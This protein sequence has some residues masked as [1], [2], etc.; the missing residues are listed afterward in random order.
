MPVESGNSAA[1]RQVKQKRK[2][3]SL[4]I[5]RTNSTEQDR[6]G[7]QRDMLEGQDSKL[8]MALRSNLMD[9][10]GQ[11][12]R[13][14]ENLYIENLELRREIDSLNERLAGE[15]QTVDGGDL[16]KGALK[17]KGTCK[18]KLTFTTTSRAV[19]QLVKEYVGHRDGIWDLA[20]TRVQPL[21]LGTASADH[22]S[23]LWS[24]ETGKCLL[25]Y[26]GHA[27]SVNSIKFHP[28]EQMALTA[29]GDQT[30][31]I[32]RYM[33]QL[34]LPQPPADISVSASLD[35]DVDFSDKDEADGEADGPNECPTIRI[36][37]TTLKSHQGVVIAADWLVG[38]KQVVTASWDR[39]ANLYDVETSELVHALTGHDQEL[40]HCCTHPTQRLVVT[41]SRDTTFR[42]WDFRDPSIHSVNVFQG[43]T[44]TVTSAVFTV[45]DN[46]VSGS[47]DRTVKVWDL[48]NMRSP[49]ATIRTD[50]AVNRI[51]VSANQRIIALPHDNR[52]VRLFDMSGVRLA[53]LPRSNRQGH[54]RMV[55]CSAWNEENQA[56]NLFT[57]GFD[58]QAIGWNINIPALLQEK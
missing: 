4:S 37:T 18:T 6:P 41:S 45:G 35:D 43:H 25:K 3:H 2:S 56:C 55:C 19:C 9:L 36:A 48:K 13:E 39:A 22:C 21:V 49:I 38:G 58:R 26:A 47:D 30:A 50:S 53:R 17:T 10:F 20:V 16:S 46:V 52:Q 11:I 24:I 42:L 5:R 28:T 12:E 27:G 14:F 57:C 33:V 34:P 44:D 51:S 1:A 31:H 32:W 15:G 40:T 29:S 8:P 23:M 54:R 7:M